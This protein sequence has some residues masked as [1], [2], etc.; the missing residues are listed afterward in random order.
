MPSH[1]MAPLTISLAERIE[2]EGL[3]VCSLPSGRFEAEEPVAEPESLNP[4]PSNPSVIVIRSGG[5]NLV[6][7]S[8]ERLGS[9]SR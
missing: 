2:G 8:P 6:Y 5:A 4:A 7:L 3:A 1:R 9:G